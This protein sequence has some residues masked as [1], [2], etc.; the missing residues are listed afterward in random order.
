MSA[1][2]GYVLV[3]Y[4]ATTLQLWAHYRSYRVAW[5]CHSR[6]TPILVSRVLLCIRVLVFFLSLS[7][8]LKLCTDNNP[9]DT[10]DGTMNGKPRNR[11]VASVENRH[12]PKT[13]LRNLEYSTRLWRLYLALPR[14]SLKN[15]MF[16]KGRKWLVC[17]FNPKDPKVKR[18]LDVSLVHTLAHERCVY[19]CMLSD[20][21]N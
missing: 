17:Y 20:P 6:Q 9:R 1:V 7:K 13:L 8:S 19:A 14:I 10:S 11:A 12:V 21:W 18:V 2:S 15:I 4:Y 5:R 16:I 3:L